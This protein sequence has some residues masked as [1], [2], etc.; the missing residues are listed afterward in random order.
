MNI[1]K[2]TKTLGT[3]KPVGE[4]IKKSLLYLF[5]SLWAIMVLF[6]FYWMLLSSI[7]SYGAY[8]SEYVPKFF[9]TSPTFENYV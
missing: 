3:P 8:N 2:K 1:K 7:K 9:T 5:L 4:I 6:P